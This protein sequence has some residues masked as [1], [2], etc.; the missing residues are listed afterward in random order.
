MTSP[1]LVLSVQMA[2]PTEAEIRG[3]LGVLCTNGLIPYWIKDRAPMLLRLACVRNLAGETNA[4]PSDDD[5]AQGLIELL[6]G[7]VEKIASSQHR[8][9]L[10]I[11]LALDPDYKDTTAK[12]RR[13]AAGELFRGGS[14]QVTWGTIRQHHEPRALDQLAALLY[15]EEQRAV[16]PGLF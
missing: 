10:T 12:E 7:L 9:L 14:R 13:T 16:T 15:G 3:E 6:G 1:F 4:D 8:I 5:L 2:S 11:V